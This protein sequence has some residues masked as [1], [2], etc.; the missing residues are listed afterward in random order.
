MQNFVV[1]CFKMPVLGQSSSHETSSRQML[2]C[3]YL[4]GQDDNS[5]KFTVLLQDLENKS[6][7]NS[8]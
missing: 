7:Y 6:A 3:S 8:A 5:N 2:H 1:K 4:E